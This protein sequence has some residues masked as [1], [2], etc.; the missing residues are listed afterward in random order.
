M[1][2]QNEDLTQRDKA[3]LLLVTATEVETWA[4]LNV[5]LPHNSIFKQHHIGDS[6]YFDLGVIGGAR[7]FLVQS[8]MG[9]GGPAGATLV[10]HEGIKALSPS[11][12]IMVGIAFGL[13]PEK[14]H[15]GDILVSQQLMGYERQKIEQGS[16][17]KEIIRHR[18]D[19]VQASP[20][21]LSRLRASI[22][23]WQE[24]KVHFGLVLSGDKLANH[25]NFRNK[26][27][28]IEPEAIGGEME[29]TGVYSAAHRNKVDWILIKAICDWADEHKDDA[30]QQ[31]AAENAARFLLHVLQQ[32]G[33]A[34]NNPGAPPPSQVPREAPPRRR[35]KGTILC[36]YY[37]HASWVLAVA[38]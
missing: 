10:V 22:F 20:R 36:T 15:I 30:Y 33:L 14:Q 24:P 25:Q 34:E 21:L 35:A 9:A 17:G 19:R 26:L 31:R 5:F 7:T 13:V 16:G 32:R 29:G 12:V 23:D 1:V 18:G 8:E 28:S 2:A 4:V 38:W 3:D 11:A 37:A 6:T 27:L